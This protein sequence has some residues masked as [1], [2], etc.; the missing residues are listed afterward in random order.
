VRL[1]SVGKRYGLRQPWI[2][3]DVSQEVAAGRLIRLEGPNGSGKS[4]L[5]RLIA[6][7]LVPSAG[8]VTSRPHAGYVP[9]RFP[10]ALAFSAREYLQHMGRIH[11]LSPAGVRAAA[12]E[13]L[14]RLGAADYAQAPLRTLSKGMCQ[15]V[16]IAQALLA[17]P[18]LLVLDEAWTGLD[19]AA[20]GALDVAVSERLDAG[21]R[22]LFADHDPARLAGRVDQRWQL[23]G[24]RVTVIPGGGRPGPRAGSGPTAAGAGPALQAATI[25][26]TGLEPPSLERLARL[27]GVLGVAAAPAGTGKQ[28]RAEENRLDR[29]RIDD[30]VRPL[31]R[32]RVTVSAAAS[33]AVLRELLSWDGVHVSGVGPAA[34]PPG[35]GTPRAA[36]AGGGA[37]AS[38]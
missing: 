34:E 33:D 31:E 37:D 9:E 15:K 28:R 29:V 20:R 14:E 5:L 6:G 25:E 38:R 13:W 10:A 3:R 7:V 2:V 4:T 22:V 16:A 18:G 27:A 8:R 12:D 36:E 32:V 19:Q 35:P 21:G 23:A 24:G 30:A 26:V 1:I 17:R 11:G